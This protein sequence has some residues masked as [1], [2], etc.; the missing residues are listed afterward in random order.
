MQNAPFI[1]EDHNYK[2]I[3]NPLSNVVSYSENPPQHFGVS[4]DIHFDE[5]TRDII[6]ANCDHLGVFFASFFSFQ[7]WSIESIKI[8]ARNSG[9][10]A[11]NMNWLNNERRLQK[12]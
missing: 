11:S 8:N 12:L 1:F 4:D 2:V 10:S 7:T 5:L 3:T 6:I 9:Y